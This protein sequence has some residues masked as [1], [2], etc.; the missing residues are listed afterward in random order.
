[1]SKQELLFQRKGIVYY[2]TLTL[3]WSVVQYYNPPIIWK[4]GFTD[5]ELFM[6]SSP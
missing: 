4:K 5:T 3:F 1:M 6:A 2:Y